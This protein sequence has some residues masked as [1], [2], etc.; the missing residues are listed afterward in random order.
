MKQSTKNNSIFFSV[1]L[2][3]AL[4]TPLNSSFPFAFVFAG[5]TNGINIVTHPIGYTG[6]GG[7]ITV[8]VGIDPTSAFAADMVISTQN[9]IDKFNNAISTTNN[10]DFSVISPTQVD[11]E[12]VLLHEMGH[13]LG[14]A[15]CNLATESGLTGADRNYTK[16]T[17]GPDGVY[18]LNPGPDGIIGSA[19]DIRG[20]DI[21]LNYFKTADNDPFSIDAIVDQTTYSRD[22][23]NLPLGSSYSTNPDRDVSALLGA[24]NTE[25]VMQQGTFSS[26]TQRSLTADDVAGIKYAM[27]GIDEIS[28]TADDYNL[29]LTYAGLTDSAD[30]VIDF[31]NSEASFAISSSGA[32]FISTDHLRIT[33]NNIYFNTGYNWFFNDV[34]SSSPQPPDVLCVPYTAVL[35]PSGTV[36]IA[37]SDVDGGTSDPN[38][39]PFTLSVFPSTF[40]CSEIG[41]NTVTLT[42]TDLDGSSSCTTTVTII[43]SGN[44]LEAICQDITVA[45]DNSGNASISANDID[46]GSTAGDCG[47]ESLF[48]T[49]VSAPV[50]LQTLFAGSTVSDGNMFDV[51]AQENIV[52][53][54]FDI[55]LQTG[56]TTN[57]EVYFKQGT[58]VGSETTSADWIF[59]ASLT[60]V[61]SNGSN[62]PTPL[63]LNLDI[64]VNSGETVA[65]YVTQTN[66]LGNFRYTA[67]TAV[68]NILA[69][70]ANLVV[71]EGAGKSY[72]FGFTFLP[73][74]FNGNVIYNTIDPFD[75]NFDTNDVGNN[76]INLN[77]RDFG[78][79]VSSCEAI[80]TVTESSLPCV[81]PP[82]LTGTP[83]T[84]NTAFASVEESTWPSNLNNAF[85]ALESKEKGL[86]LTRMASPETTIGTGANAI[87]GMLVYDTDDNCLKLYNGTTWNCLSKGCPD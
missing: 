32:S 15:H 84:S 64:N 22:I 44:P 65:F 33:N 26:E 73:R 41:E 24:P 61:T 81:R 13:S 60:G 51:Q 72:P 86:V 47:I 71:F 23:S 48:M 38:G 63:N 16:S 74:S 77:V 46:G 53:N 8:T 75:G 11:F 49:T 68:G 85:L 52:I 82:L 70:D 31:D 2:F 1:I 66:N 37:A 14:L 5:T 34:P 55:N 29:V 50:N 58:W 83:Q 10:I 42:A 67:G 17:P 35:S 43:D 19:D 20:D 57:I 36:T 69:S 3:L 28:G 27:S 54:S 6:A 80:V 56:I 12:S 78:G 40:T 59:A 39:D 76:F 79:N 45:L 30:I 21:N 25:G 62:N 4:F 18:G 9:V 87:A 7:T